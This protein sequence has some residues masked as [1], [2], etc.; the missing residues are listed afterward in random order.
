MRSA[1]ARSP[2]TE[3][4]LERGHGLSA[5]IVAK[6]EFI[7][8]NLKL[9]AAHAVIGSDQPLL[10]IPNGAVR[11]RQHRL[12]AFA[13]IDSQGLRARHMLK[14]GLLQPRKALET[15][16]IY[17]RTQHYIF[18]QETEERC[19]FEIR[20][21]SHSSAPGYAAPFLHNHQDQR[22]FPSLQ[23]PASPQSGLSPA[24]PGLVHFHFSAQRLTFQV[25]HSPPQLVQHHPCCL[26]ALQTKLALQKKR[27]DPTLIGS[28]QISSPEPD[29]QGD[30]GVMKDCLCRH[31]NLVPT[32]GALPAFQFHQFISTLVA[33]S[34]THKPIRPAA[35][36]QVFLT[37][38][39]RGELRL[40][41]RQSFRKRR[42]RHPYTTA[43]GLL[44]QPDKHKPTS[45]ARKTRTIDMRNSA[46]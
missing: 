44:K 15:V 30:L 23:L 14:S 12:R 25:D 40:K 42:A 27:R 26:V 35:G 9:I 28:H 37:S 20:D 22:G 2:E 18:F 31:R 24:N 5:P 41:F 29:R 32:A 21:D 34:R 46:G 13:Q 45:R 1:C 7:K 33:A 4:G 8:I 11:Q 19:T 6:D 38:L 17:S 10:E 3:Q 36:G 43:C 16:S 39:F